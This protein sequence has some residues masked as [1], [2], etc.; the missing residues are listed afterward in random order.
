M[1]QLQKDLTELQRYLN[2]SSIGSDD[3]IKIKSAIEKINKI[4]KQG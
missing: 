1:S 2:D 3:K 4:L